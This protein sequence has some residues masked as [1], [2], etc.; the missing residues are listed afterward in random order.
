MYSFTC[1]ILNNLLYT[2]ECDDWTYGDNC[3]Y[4]CNCNYYG[5]KSCNKENGLCNCK[6][7]WTASSC[8]E[9]VNECILEKPPCTKEH[10]NA[11]CTNTGGSFECRCVKNFEVFNETYC[12][13]KNIVQL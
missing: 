1:K 13:G 2:I 8:N 5:T 12:N 6:L 7:E 10:D 11:V 4:S 9:D 3:A